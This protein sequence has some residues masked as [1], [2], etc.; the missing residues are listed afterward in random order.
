MR[1]CANQQIHVQARTY[2]DAWLD[3]GALIE[4]RKLYW[5][6]RVVDVCAYEV[7]AFYMHCSLLVFS[8]LAA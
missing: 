2:D 8:L 7:I 6:E 1:R 3:P 4:L 5:L